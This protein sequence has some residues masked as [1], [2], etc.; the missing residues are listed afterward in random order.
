MSEASQGGV[1]EA[2][3]SLEQVGRAFP[4]PS[5]FFLYFFLFYFLTELLESGKA[6][7]LF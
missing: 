7:C 4:N 1:R 3:V 2:E 5:F 6:E